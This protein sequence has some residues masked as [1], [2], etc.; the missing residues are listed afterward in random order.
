MT[1][2]NRAV[3]SRKSIAPTP[4]LPADTVDMR[5]P[6]QWA[7][8]FRNLGGSRNDRFNNVLVNT[9][10]RTLWHH[11]DEA[12]EVR[13]DKL[14]AVAVALKG[15]AP[16][17]EVE[18]MLAA[19]AVGLHAATMECLRRA[20]LPDQPGEFASK[21]RRDAVNCARAMAEMCAALDRRRGK[22]QQ[23]VR[24]EHVTVQSGGQAIVGTVAP[25]V[26]AAPGGGE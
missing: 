5:A 8:T 2:E 10:A 14:T 7:G 25:A 21:L 26:P 13:S 1:K 11:R 16:Q 24:V 23:T 12:A 6:D 19:Q 3:P 4:T 17:D 22:G 9:A 20:M 15:F 18:G